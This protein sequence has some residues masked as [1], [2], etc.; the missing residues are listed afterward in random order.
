MNSG[1]FSFLS[2]RRSLHCRLTPTSGLNPRIKS[3]TLDSSSTAIIDDPT[4]AFAL[5][6][7]SPVK[8]CA[9]VR[10][11][12]LMKR[13]DEEGAKK[14]QYGA[15]PLIW[16][17]IAVVEWQ[18]LFW[19]PLHHFVFLFQLLSMRAGGSRKK[20]T[21]GGVWVAW[22]VIKQWEKTEGVVALG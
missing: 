10:V 20:T 16:W 21:T 12:V 4:S 1:P 5:E 11:M 3:V 13:K 14:E 9:R 2:S 6:E 7:E 8:I 22:C 19:Q 17:F 15:P 18:G